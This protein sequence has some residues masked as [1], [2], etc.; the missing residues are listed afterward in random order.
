MI[1]EKIT[2]DITLYHADCFDVMKQL[3]KGSVDL[4]VTDPPYLFES[5]GAGHSELGKRAGNLKDNIDFIS[6]D[7]DWEK[8]FEMFLELQKIPNML[9]FCSNRQLSRTMRFFEDKGLR[10][11]CLVWHKLNPIPLVNKTYMQDVEFVVRVGG[12]GATFNNECPFDYKRKVYTSGIVSNKNR[13]H[14]TQKDLK[15]ISQFVELHSKEGDLLFDAFMGSGTTP[16][17]CHLLNR[18]CI[19]VELDS[20][21][22]GVASNRLKENAQQLKLF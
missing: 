18:K 12:E 8:C 10:V 4:I 16:L 22:F 17:A 7:F 21:F 2:N 3:P 1:E 20:H 9:I 11:S 5:G 19:G 6:A 14:P 15:H 13:L